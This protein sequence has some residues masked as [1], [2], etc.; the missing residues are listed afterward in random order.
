MPR[1]QRTNF[2]KR[3]SNSFWGSSHRPVWVWELW[4]MVLRFAV[5]HPK[6]SET[7]ELPMGPEAGSPAA[8]D[9]QP[10]RWSISGPISTPGARLANLPGSTWN[11]MSRNFF[12]R[13]Y[14]MTPIL[15][16][17]PRSTLGT[18]R[19]VAYLKVCLSCIFG[20]FYQKVHHGQFGGDK[21]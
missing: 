10:L 5:S 7:S 8:I 20:F 12:R 16:N 17:S 14:R 15:K 3:Q 19:M 11:F 2:S 6:R 21:L 18:M 1:D 13:Q 9:F 4:R